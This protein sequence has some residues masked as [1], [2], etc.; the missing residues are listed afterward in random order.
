VSEAE[1]RDHGAV[2]L[3][4]ASDPGGMPPDSIKAR[5]PDLVAEV[6]RSFQHP[7]QGRLALTRIG[8]AMIRPQAEARAPH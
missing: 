5:F 2:L 3:W 8:W 1:I 4:P 7:V 6:P